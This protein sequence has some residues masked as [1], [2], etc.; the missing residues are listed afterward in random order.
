MIVPMKK[1][2][3]ITQAKEADETIRILGKLGV[4]HIEHQEVPHSKDLT[5]LQEDKALL[6][7]AI[8]IFTGEFAV[9]N[10]SEQEGYNSD[11]RKLCHHIIELHKRI[12][13]L[14]EYFRNLSLTVQ[15]W[16][17]W[18]DFDPE[19]IISLREKGI[20]I[21][22][23]QIPCNRIKEL[24]E[25]IIVK[26]V[27]V[28]KGVA[29]SLIISR[30]SV[31]IPFKE[32]PLPRMGLSDMRK[33]LAEDKRVM[34]EVKEEIQKNSRFYMALQNIK[35]TLNKDIELQEA[36]S[37]MGKSGT[38]SYLIGFVPFDKATPVLQEAKRQAWGFVVS[39]PAEEDRVPTLVHNPRWISL[40]EPIFRV[41]EIVPGYHELDISLWFLIFLS[42]FFGIIV[43]DAA[44]GLVF[45]A[46]AVFLKYKLKKILKDNAPIR[47]LY[48]FSFSA[49]VWGILSG[50]YFGQEWLPAWVKPVVP[51][52]RQ[53]NTVQT[54]C[55]FIGAL[56]L[57][58][59]HIWR[60]LLKLPSLTALVDAGWILILWGA[61]FLA[62]VL[63]LGEMFP[64]SGK[65]LF[66]AGIAL[67]VLFT[68]L[69]K[70]VLKGIGSGLGN[71]AM[72]L[73]N[74][75]TDVVSYIRLFAVGLAGLAVAEAFNKMAMD[76][77]FG[78][79]ITAILSSLVLLGGHSLNILLAPM[80]IIVHGVRLNILEFSSHAD[81][82]WSGYK[83][84]PFKN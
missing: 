50:T 34:E 18:E 10:L 26:V 82:K 17:P 31:E 46:L 15:F 28:F 72:N 53:N 23:Y 14:R 78:S 80:S 49:I 76:I 77:G 39:D 62:R 27:R 57:S 71:L 44:Y 83:Y 9:K 65:W 61:F 45:L 47:L 54:L 68:K 81:I 58:I 41:I 84:R 37:G 33:R 12:L 16:E 25:N 70:N 21:R 13:H 29:Y 38:I 1:T 51:S 11:W 74:N 22:L 3:I 52:L 5:A 6:E 2:A 55:F 24:P 67:V 48:I 43:G 20:F 56:H 42:L 4:V 66:F 64:P 59:A 19:E 8:S 73:V 79:L 69:Q 40:I 35:Q 36:I 30:E 60:L 32:T 7:S 63:I 75:F